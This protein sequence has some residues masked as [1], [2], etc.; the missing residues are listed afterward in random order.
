MDE[1][2]D[3]KQKEYDIEITEED[4][5]EFDPEGHYYEDY[6]LKHTKIQV[7]HVDFIGYTVEAH[8][9]FNDAVQKVNVIS[10]PDYTL[11]VDDEGEIVIDFGENDKAFEKY[12][13]IPDEIALEDYIVH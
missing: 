7:E 6:L 9:F 2:I 12:E 5:V 1:W 3:F 10:F 8:Y 4:I 13:A 11:D